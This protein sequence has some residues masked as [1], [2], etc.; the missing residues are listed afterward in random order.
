MKVLMIRKKKK[1]LK[2]SEKVEQLQRRGSKKDLRLSSRRSSGV[3]EV[4][5]KRLRNIFEQKSPE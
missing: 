3:V 4:K 2:S 1:V 5:K